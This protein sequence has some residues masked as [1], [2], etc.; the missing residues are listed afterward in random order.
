MTRQSTVGKYARED[1]D[2][3]LPEYR[4]KC[5]DVVGVE[6]TVG[7]VKVRSR[8][9]WQAEPRYRVE[10]ASLMP[11]SKRWYRESELEACP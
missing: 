3:S 2:A 1:R 5:G 7:I 10:P 11:L 4:F 8:R 6:N 9:L